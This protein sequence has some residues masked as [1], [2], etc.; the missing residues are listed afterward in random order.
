MALYFPLVKKVSRVFLIS[1]YKNVHLT[2]SLNLP[3]SVHRNGIGNRLTSL[4]QDLILINLIIFERNFEGEALIT[5]SV[6]FMNFT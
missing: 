5:C 6:S 1:L 4:K 2:V 3:S